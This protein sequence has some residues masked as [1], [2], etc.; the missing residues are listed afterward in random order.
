MWP[1][2]RPVRLL[3]AFIANDE[4]DFVRYRLQAHENLTYRVLIAEANVSLTREPKPWYITDALTAAERRRFNVR[5]VHMP[6][7]LQ[8]NAAGRDCSVRPI[9]CLYA[10]YAPVDQSGLLDTHPSIVV[11][12]APPLPGGKYPSTALHGLP[13]SPQ[14]ALL[15]RHLAE[16]VERAGPCFY[17]LHTRSRPYKHLPPCPCHCPIPSR[18]ADPSE[19][20]EINDGMRYGLNV[21][22]LEELEALPPAARSPAAS[23]TVFV[24]I[25]DVDEI[26]VH[27]A[28]CASACFLYPP[29][30]LSLPLSLSLSLALALSHSHSHSHTYTPLSLP[31]LRTSRRW[32]GA[33]RERRRCTRGSCH[34]RGDPGLQPQTLPPT[35]QLP[36]PPPKLPPPQLLPTPPSPL[37]PSPPPPTPPPPPPP[38]CRMRIGS[39]Q[40]SS[41][42]ISTTGHSM[43]Q[44]RVRQSREQQ[45]AQAHRNSH[46]LPP[47]RSPPPLNRSSPPLLLLLRSIACRRGCA[48]FSTGHFAQRR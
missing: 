15:Q 29:P 26:L 22:V 14:R 40:P 48:T 5:L 24:H 13:A 39:T 19:L 7:T 36:T 3:D 27:A 18:A 23:A 2:T 32:S 21:A 34:T 12:S 20:K 8:R 1:A 46:R 44:Q 6:F 45:P 38:T 28:C 41:V 31:L 37:P 35:P 42:D 11:P 4:I 10:A 43:R 33:W 30:H 25:S 16:Q 47:H 9:R 17:T